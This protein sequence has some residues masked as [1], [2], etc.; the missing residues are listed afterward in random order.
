MNG[1]P[2]GQQHMHMMIKILEE[3]GNTLYLVVTADVQT[4]IAVVGTRTSG[5]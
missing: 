5:D 4:A 3:M 1:K 2:L